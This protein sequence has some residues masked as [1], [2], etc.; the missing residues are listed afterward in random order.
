MKETFKNNLFAEFS[1]RSISFII[2]RIVLIIFGSYIVVIEEINII[3]EIN[4]FSV[5]LYIAITIIIITI[6]LLI[7]NNRLN[8]NLLLR[9]NKYYYV[10]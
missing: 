3:N 2:F 9:I 5:S 7:L 8:I 10:Y 6:Y 1:F 4:Y